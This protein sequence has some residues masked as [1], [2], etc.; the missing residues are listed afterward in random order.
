MNIKIVL[1]PDK[2]SLYRDGELVAEENVTVSMS[3]LGKNLK[4]Y[5]GRSFYEPDDLYFRGFFDNV[6]FMTSR[7]EATR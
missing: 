7:W 1:T 2:M 5:L 6:R 4:A 3:D